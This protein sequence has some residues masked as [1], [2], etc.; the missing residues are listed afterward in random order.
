MIYQNHPLLAPWIHK[1]LCY[2]DSIAAYREF[3]QGKPWDVHEFGA[4]CHEA[5]RKGV[6]T[7]D[8]NNDGD[9]SDPGESTIRDPQKFVDFLGLP[10][11]FIGKKSLSDHAKYD[12]LDHW[13][14]TAWRWQITHWVI[15]AARPV[16]W[17]PWMGGSA[18]VK[19]GA[20]LELAKDGSGGLVVFEVR[21]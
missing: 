15:G 21:K 16:F 17:D 9:M 19:N 2:G 11:R 7:G 12:N 1:A 20:P 4:M 18:T 6:I 3:R 10:L 13:V 8:L 14:L 5:V